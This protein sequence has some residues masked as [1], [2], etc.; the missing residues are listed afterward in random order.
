M[1]A[2]KTRLTSVNEYV[3]PLFLKDVNIRK[4]E[5]WNESAS[6][7]AASLLVRRVFEDIQYLT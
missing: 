7:G 2:K 6:L 3:F 5:A 1:R 4:S